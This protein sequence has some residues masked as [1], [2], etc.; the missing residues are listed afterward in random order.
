[1]EISLEMILD[2]LVNYKLSY[3][4]KINGRSQIRGVKIVN[5]CEI[6]YKS[7]ILYI[8][9]ASSFP[10]KIPGGHDLSI[11]CIKDSTLLPH[12]L[13]DCKFN[14]TILQNPIEINTL[15]EEIQDIISAYN[16]WSD[17]LLN[18]L[19]QEKELQHIIDIGYELLENPILMTDTGLRLLA[20]IKTD[21]TDDFRWNNIVQ[22]GYVSEDSIPIMELKKL[23]QK[24]KNANMPIIVE[25][26]FFKHSQLLTNILVNDKLVGTLCVVQFNRP[27]RESDVKLAQFLSMIISQV[28]KKNELIH[29]SKG[30]MYEYLINDLLEGKLQSNEVIKERIKYLNWE[31]NKNIYILTIRPRELNVS[32]EQIFKTRDRLTNFFTFG[33]CAVYNEYIIIVISQKKEY[34]FNP[35]DLNRLTVFLEKS[36][37]YGGISQCFHNLI[38]I[39][40][41]YRQALKAIDLGS[42]ISTANVVFFYK[43][44][45]VNHIMDI[46]AEQE[47]LRIFCHPSIFI[48]LEYDEKNHVNFTES[49]YLYIK[50]FGNQL[51]TSKSLFIHRNTLIYRLDKI[52][53]IMQINLK[54]SNTLFHL[55]LSF[56][57]L[58]YLKES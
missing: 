5:K 33:K 3:Y 2:R 9:T 8:T 12:L 53:K 31:L 19:F 58:D 47:D 34:P 17:K 24:Q 32:H 16:Q 35:E 50:N 29:N 46:C 30:I 40:K 11:I 20:H 39:K 25:A 1:M 28:M 51:A 10:E 23:L 26:G 49:L 36:G 42:S 38:E 7:D 15:Y 6:E 4:S 22:K 43:D 14:L 57:I 48:L 54:D 18:S 21:K 44:Y 41:Y 27:F 55:H 13:N 37:M 56:K 45:I 52:E